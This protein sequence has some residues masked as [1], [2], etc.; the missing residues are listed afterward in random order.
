MSKKRRKRQKMKKKETK[1][2]KSEERKE[3]VWT[4]MKKKKGGQGKINGGKEGK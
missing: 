1:Q 4:H 3:K 2:L